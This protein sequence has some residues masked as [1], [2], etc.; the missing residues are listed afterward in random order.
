M[1]VYL[2]YYP[3]T[4]NNIPKSLF[5]IKDKELDHFTEAALDEGRLCNVFS[6]PSP[7]SQNPGKVQRI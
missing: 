6:L 4:H 2:K 3:A 7:S 1:K 5:T